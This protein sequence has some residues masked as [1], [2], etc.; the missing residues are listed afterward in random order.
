MLTI[1]IEEILKL[2]YD[3]MISIECDICKKHFTRMQKFVK[4]ELK[5][6]PNKK[7]CCS[8]QCADLTRYTRILVNCKQ[9][10]KSFFK[11]SNQLRRN[12]NSFCD[13]SCSATYQNQNKTYGSRRSKLECYLEKELISLYP[14]LDFHFNRKDAIKSEL[15]IYISSLK[16][17]FELNGIFHY[18]PIFGQ[19]KLQ[20]ILNNDQRK[21]QACFEK[22]IELCVIDSS[23][24][25]N[26]K[27]N[28]AKEYLKIITDIID[29]KL[30]N[31]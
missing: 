8:K 17:A 14:N 28:K 18:E 2:P 6:T 22:G 25:K 19:D 11:R 4:F 1:S 10:G 12:P 7:W 16:L 20:N 13:H 5:N 24:M 3:T 23:S 29:Q 27:E 9:C 15:D 31:S 30:I 26:F 21:F